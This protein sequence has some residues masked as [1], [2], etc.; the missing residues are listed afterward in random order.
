MSHAAAQPPDRAAQERKA[1]FFLFYS[2]ENR[3]DFSA[4]IEM[5]GESCAQRQIGRLRAYDRPQKKIV[6][7]GWRSRRA[8]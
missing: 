2:F 8:H 4:L 3:R 7:G 1:M 5:N 6:G